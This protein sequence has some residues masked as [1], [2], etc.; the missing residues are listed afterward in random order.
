MSSRRTS[1]RL[2]AAATATLVAI[3]LSVLASHSA[4]AATTSASGWSPT[5]TK[6][7]TLAH[8][9]SLGAAPAATPLRL[10]VGLTPRDRAGIDRLIK[11]QATPGNASYGKFLTPAEFT[12]RFAATSADAQAVSSY[13]SGAGMK[14]VAVS[15]NRLQVTADATV[16]QAQ[17][18][19]H[20][21]IARFSQAGRTVLA[22][23]AAAQVPGSLAGKV[24]G[25]LGLSTLGV[26]ASTPSLPKLTGFYPDEF[27]KVY[28]AT[29]TKAGTGTTL[30]VLAQGD[31]TQTVKDLRTFEAKRK[32]PQVPVQLV[33]TGVKS[34]DTAGADEW[35][36][37][38][39]TSTGIASSAKKLYIYV[40]TSLSDADLARSVNA[41]AAQDVARSGSASLGEC[42]ALPYLDGSMVVDDIALAEAAV[43]GQTFFASSG[44]TGS[45]CAVAP[46]N[47][48]PGAGLP[49]TEYPASSPYAVGVGG[50]T[51]AATD[52]DAY[53]SEITWNAGGGGISP[54]ENGGYWQNN[55]VPSS[56]GA[57]RGVPDVAFDADPNTGALITVDGADEQIGGTSLASPL[58]L[59]LWTRLQSSHGN[60]LGFA[61][62]KLYAI[63]SKAQ[64]T[65]PLPPTTVPASFHDVVLG[66]NGAYPAT[67]GYDYTTGLGSWDVA[68]LSAAIR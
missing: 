54:V 68:K 8:A 65:P 48:V 10:T 12:S 21:S 57:L 20:T 34:P 14:N 59:G 6:A 52:S 67:P 51:L 50:T 19:F 62:P 44:D 60:A 3:P 38:T 40:E 39:Q 35:D 2:A 1:R 9:T 25:V 24:S 15:S 36:L 5:A 41:F 4:D 18:A 22:N 13:L 31:L 55:V 23:T 56:A 37:D 45:S 29:S 33:Y 53:T 27:N 32:L 43:Q 11:A 26:S 30:A 58:A 47:G 61:P 66:S 63:Y 42:D 46:T 28:D 49:D 16:A 64:T 17:S 7:L